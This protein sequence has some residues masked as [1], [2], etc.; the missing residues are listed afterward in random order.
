MVNAAIES[1]GIISLKKSSKLLNV[2]V[3]D[4]KNARRRRWNNVDQTLDKLLLDKRLNVTYLTALPKSFGGQV[5]VFRTSDIVITPH[6]AALANS[7]F[8]KKGSEV[9]EINKCCRDEVRLAPEALRAWTGW[10]APLLSIGLQYLQ[11]HQE[12][13][14][15]SIAELNSTEHRNAEDRWCNL[16]RFD[17]NPTDVMQAV[18]KAISR[19]KRKEVK[20][21]PMAVPYSETKLQ[22]IIFLSFPFLT[23]L[24]Y[25]RRRRRR[26][27]LN[28]KSNVAVS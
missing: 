20:P 6:G 5:S 3:Y 8:M 15:L 14:H 26:R 16:K 7:I 25:K 10:H 12:N 22:I 18:R 13:S 28:G 2:L 21:S 27:N 17:V 23:L 9:I 19:I 11:C 24:L 4:R 1:G